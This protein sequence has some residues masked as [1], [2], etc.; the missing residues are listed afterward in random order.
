MATLLHPLFGRPDRSAPLDLHALLGAPAWSRLPAAVRRRFGAGHGEAVYTGRMDLH[1]SPVGRVFAW[2][3]R[4]VGSP[5][6]ATCATGVAATVRVHEDK[7]GGMVWARCFGPDAPGTPRV[8]STK[9]LAPDGSLFERTDG[10]LGMAL[11]AYEHNGSLVF[12]SLRYVFVLGRRR[13]G[14]PS[15]LTPGTCRVTH[16][17]LGGGTFRFSLEMVHP[18]WGRTFHQTGV[19]ADP[20]ERA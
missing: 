10:G 4:I 12:E 15:W 5:L 19:F 2:L 9:E 6:T 17:D 1:C 8:H 20:E 11:I 13:I 14:I 18:L 3:S 7:N 16:T